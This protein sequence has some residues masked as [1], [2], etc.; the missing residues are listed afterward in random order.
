[1]IPP[2][3][4]P[5][6]MSVFGAM[7]RG[8]L[9]MLFV[10]AI[11]SSIPASQSPLIG[12]AFEYLAEQQDLFHQSA[13]IY[14]E[15]D[16][17]AALFFP[18]GWMGNLAHGSIADSLFA[19]TD[20]DTTEPATGLTC[21]KVRVARGFHKSRGWLGIYWQNPD[22]NWGEHP[23]LDLSRYAQSGR[24]WLE[25]SARGARGGER[26]RFLS[27]GIN[28]P[29]NTNRHFKYQDSYGPVYPEGSRR[30][31]LVHLSRH[32]AIYR[33]DLT[34]RDLSNVIGA[35][36]WELE[37]DQQPTETTFYLDDVRIVFGR[38]GTTRRLQEPR[39]IRSYVP[40]R[41]GAPDR[42]FRNVAFTYD[43]ALAL[44]AFLAGG[45][46]DRLRRAKLIA[47]AFVC[48]QHLDPKVADGRLRSAYSCGDLLT[49]GEYCHARLPGFWDDQ[50]QQWD[51]DSTLV[52]ADCGNIA[53]VMIALLDYWEKSG[54]PA[55]S[56]Y[57]KAAERLGAWVQDT[58][59]HDEGFGGFSGGK[60]GWPNEEPVKEK[61]VLWRSTEH[62]IDLFV[63]F[64]RLHAA[65]GDTV[66]KN[67]AQHAREFVHRMWDASVGH[68]W[69]GTLEDGTPNKEVVPLD[70]H[71]WAILALDDQTFLP[72]LEWAK[73]HCWSVADGDSGCGGFDFKGD[74]A[75]L[76]VERGIWWEGTAQMQ[77]ALRMTD[78][79]FGADR[80][81]ASV[82]R[83]GRDSAHRGAVVAA[84]SDSLPTGFHL[85]N[86]SSWLYYRRPHIGATAWYLFAELGWNPYWG[87][88]VDRKK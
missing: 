74:A 67:P 82:R 25:F 85:A 58:T 24:V 9:P 27:G 38:E 5:I 65:T 22:R 42:Y 29:P 3:L 23:G 49:T 83:C 44:I 19:M 40:L 64:S 55:S 11:A 48:A 87:R 41:A 34:G 59:Y 26:I 36:A 18:S 56:P 88:P 2:R 77:L 37:E 8:A 76:G 12:E 10:P 45:D 61:M 33:I 4:P 14:D 70:V 39:F 7:L 50:R 75:T 72:G 62:N 86:G 66:W 78:D 81:L 53:W 63:A 73:E 52:G 17:G 71:P 60:I 84:A 13:T 47:D 79:N 32:W 31:G 16:S 57:L 68:F 15:R 35:F 1:M 6:P 30:G 20:A 54:K 51:E 43:N 69:T 80:C 28:R 46:P 21:V